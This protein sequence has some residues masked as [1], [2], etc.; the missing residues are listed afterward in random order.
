MTTNS[1]PDN[2]TSRDDLVERIELMEAMIAEGR[3]PTM[4]SGWIFILWGAVDLAGMGWQKLPHHTQWVW[5]ICIAL[6]LALQVAIAALRKR[7]RRSGRGM[8]CRSVMA[9]WGMMG[10]AMLIYVGT[11]LFT[12]FAWQYSYLAAI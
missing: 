3:Q 6:G 1:E 11:A 9:V 5:P 8:E 7:E 12:H 4:R 2:G 10:I